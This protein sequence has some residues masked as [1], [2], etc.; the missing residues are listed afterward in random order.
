[1][2]FRRSTV[3]SR[4][5]PPARRL[6][7]LGFASQRSASRGASLLPR[8]S[9]GDFSRRELSQA[10]SPR[11]LL[12]PRPEARIIP[13]NFSRREG[14]RSQSPSGDSSRRD[15]KPLNSSYRVM[16]SV[17]SPRNIPMLATSVAVVRKML[18]A[19]AGSAPSLR[20]V[21]GISAPEMPLT[22]QLP[23]IAMNTISAS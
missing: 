4:S 8:E 1:M 20:N 13:G 2:A 10:A 18:D 7:L 5:A 3:R 14:S 17:A 19:V 6:R 16:I 23:I 11:R 9:S 15:R 12:A 22:T 21:R